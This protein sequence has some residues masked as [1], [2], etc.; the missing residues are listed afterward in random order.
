MGGNHYSVCELNCPE[1]RVVV[2]EREQKSI[3]RQ[4]IRWEQ[5]KEGDEGRISGN[6]NWS[7]EVPESR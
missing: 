3:W 6:T 1:R 2:C 5:A 4:Q 7:D